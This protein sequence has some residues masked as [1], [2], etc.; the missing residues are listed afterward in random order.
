MTYQD[1][2]TLIAYAEAN[3][4]TSRQLERKLNREVAAVQHTIALPKEQGAATLMRFVREYVNHCQRLIDA[5]SE[6]GEQAGMMLEIAPVINLI[7]DFFN[8]GSQTPVEQRG[9]VELMDEAYL[10]HRLVEEVNERYLAETG[11]P[12]IALDMTTANLVV[13]HL[14]G[15]PFAN[16]LD[17]VAATAAESVMANR[18][19]SASEQADRLQERPQ[20][21]DQAWEHWA[22]VYQLEN[23]GLHLAH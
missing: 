19:L 15:E 9:L 4:Q 20:N 14:I 10:A 23:V 11:A 2:R 21:W 5:L 13:H 16:E 18:R 1:I 22:Q 7:E 3:E 17:D 8:S 6:A 12:L